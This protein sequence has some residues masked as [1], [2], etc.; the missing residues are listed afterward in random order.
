M[1]KTPKQVKT[2]DGSSCLQYTFN[3]ESADR[4]SLDMLTNARIPGFFKPEFYRSDGDCVLKWRTDG[5]LPCGEYLSACPEGGLFRLLISL[6]SALVSAE[7]FFLESNPILLD[8]EFLYCDP[9][10]GDVRAICIPD[11]ELSGQGVCTLF[12]AGPGIAGFL[13]DIIRWA[14]GG[15][16]SDAVCPETQ[17]V[18]KESAEFHEGIMRLVRDAEDAMEALQTMPV[19][20]P[21]EFSLMLVGLA[22]SN[23]RQ[24]G[25]GGTGA[26]EKEIV[27]PKLPIDLSCGCI[28]AGGAPENAEIPFGFLLRIFSLKNLRLFLK[29]R[30]SRPGLPGWT[31]DMRKRIPAAYLLESGKDDPVMIRELP[32][33]IGKASSSDYR[34]QGNRS[35]SREH[36][37]ILF[38]EGCYLIKDLSST[39]GTYLNGEKLEPGKLHPLRPGD[40][41]LMGSMRLSFGTRCSFSPQPL[42]GEE[43]G[44]VR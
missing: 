40:S 42:C 13:D 3:I 6:C 32:F 9:Q 24:P 38:G 2:L 43:G 22:D 1:K 5:F 18:R 37:E 23:D 8:R 28:A 10:S 7:N 14:G 17:P 20:S 27:S 16:S 25:R 19:F 30:R 35:V 11:A 12:T 4:T 33:R 36:A 21:G 41:L 39:N 44:T 15:K 29:S 31:P 34:V 26:D